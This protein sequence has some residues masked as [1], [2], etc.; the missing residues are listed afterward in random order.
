MTPVTAVPTTNHASGTSTSLA[1]SSGRAPAAPR[2]STQRAADRSK[3]EREGHE[4]VGHH[5]RRAEPEADLLPRR[6]RTRHRRHQVPARVRPLRREPCGTDDQ[7]EQQPT[8]RH[9]QRRLQ[10]D[11]RARRDEHEAEIER[12][13][14]GGERRTRQPSAASR[15]SSPCE[16]RIESRSMRPEGSTVLTALSSV[17][18]G[19]KTPIAPDQSS[20]RPFAS[21]SAPSL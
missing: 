11:D 18:S 14:P 9:R 5:E 4:A 6:A 19:T 12:H 1:G 17:S 16:G 2:R 3:A 21:A 7:D 20:A 10:A 13:V 15:R 8:R